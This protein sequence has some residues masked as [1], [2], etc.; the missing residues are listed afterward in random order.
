LTFFPVGMVLRLLTLRPA[1]GVV[2]YH[3]CLVTSLAL[4]PHSRRPPRYR[5]VTPAARHLIFAL[6]YL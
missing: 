5:V 2:R 1:R 4:P 6:L 3:L